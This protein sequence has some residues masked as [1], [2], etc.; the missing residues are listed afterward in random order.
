MAIVGD[1]QKLEQLRSSL[2][3]AGSPSFRAQLAARL[4]REALKLV[5]DGFRKQ[6]DPYGHAWAPLKAQRRRQ[7]PKKRGDRIGVN[8]GAMRNG[9]YTRADASGFRLGNGRGYSLFFNDGTR[10]G[11]VPRRMVP[12]GELGQ[13]WATAFRRESEKALR[14]TFAGTGAL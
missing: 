13:L 1:F 3:H 2:R 9:F 10:R 6:E 11:L 8:T 7:G 4:G 5:A 14:E 12:Q